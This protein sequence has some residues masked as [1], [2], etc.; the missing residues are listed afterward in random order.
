MAPATY[1]RADALLTPL[2]LIPAVRKGQIL[3]ED[4]EAEI[5]P[6]RRAITIVAIGKRLALAGFV[7]NGREALESGRRLKA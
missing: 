7:M 4:Q 6:E 5:I 1:Q 2:P 3:L